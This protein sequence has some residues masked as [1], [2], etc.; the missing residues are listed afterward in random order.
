MKRMEKRDDTLVE[1]ETALRMCGGIS[2]S[3]RRRL[4]DFPRPIVLSRTRSG[5][6]CRIAFVE[7]ELRD[8]VARKIAAYRSEAQ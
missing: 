2:D 1:L 8:Y 7:S 6:P 5:R 4:A 3:T